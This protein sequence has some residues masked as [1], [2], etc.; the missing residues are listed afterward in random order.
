M[1][2]YR[3]HTAEQLWDSYFSSIWMSSTWRTD[4]ISELIDQRGYVRNTML[5]PSRGNAISGEFE[6]K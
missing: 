1:D 3:D 5:T 4:A 2:E 6:A